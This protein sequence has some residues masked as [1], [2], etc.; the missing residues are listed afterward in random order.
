MRRLFA[1]LLLCTALMMAQAVFTITKTP[2]EEFDCSFDFA[3]VVTSD[4][5]VFDSIQAVVQRNQNA[6]ATATVI[7]TSPVPAVLSGTA[8]VIFRVRGGNSGTTYHIGVRV[9]NATTGEKYEGELLLRI[10]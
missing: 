6:D 3:A 7:A 5:I 4:V 1:L 8:K 2:Y 10:S 9:H